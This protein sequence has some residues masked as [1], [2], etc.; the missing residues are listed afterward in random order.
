[1]FGKIDQILKKRIDEVGFV[2][3]K[4]EA[5]IAVKDL[6]LDSK[7]PLPILIMDIVDKV[8]GVGSEDL[9]TANI[10][11]GM[12]F[13]VGVE[14]DFQFNEYYKKVLKIIDENI[15]MR[16]LGIALEMADNGDRGT[17]I[18]YLRAARQILGDD[19]SVIY[20]YGRCCDE[21]GNLGGDDSLEEKE[22]LNEAFETFKYIV[23]KYPDSPL[24]Y[25]HLGFYFVNSKQYQKAI[26]IWGEALKHELG[27]EKRMEVLKYLNAITAKADYEKGYNLV[28][29]G[30]AQ[31]GLEKLLPLEEEHSDWWN[32][33]FFIGLG[34]RMLKDYEK[35]IQYFQ[36]VTVL[37]TGHVETF[38]EIG[39]C[40]MSL[41]YFDQALKVF[42]EAA[43]M[44]PSNAEIICNQ[45]ISAIQ[46]DRL[47][48]A[49]ELLERAH[50]VDPEDE[51]VLAWMKEL[52]QLKMS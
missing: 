40:Y 17:A 31:E 38:N 52:N 1:M 3:L 11:R 33:M 43:K 10:M 32:L 21:L 22:Y 24:G 8:N 7:I 29:D 4:P 49:E 6:K 42:E 19:L 34:Y 15:G 36:K 48:E 44:H 39:L 35:A 25:Y 5:E 20:N 2:E 41:G 46:L 45:A 16:L 28:L 26:D 30:R 23:E 37:N 14:Y 50:K 51:I 18:I 13:M 12:A 9:N 47:E 27:D